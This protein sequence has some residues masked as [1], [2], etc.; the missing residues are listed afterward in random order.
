MTILPM[1]FAI[2]VS[3]SET[4]SEDTESMSTKRVPALEDA[5]QGIEL[6]AVA[7]KMKIEEHAD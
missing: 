3:E 7:M 4:Y 5:I 2:R 6:E 1:K